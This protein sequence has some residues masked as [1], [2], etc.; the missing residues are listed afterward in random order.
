MINNLIFSLKNT[1]ASYNK[2]QIS[3]KKITCVVEVA[4]FFI[5]IVLLPLS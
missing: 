5:K 3:S 4:L 1:G 2:N